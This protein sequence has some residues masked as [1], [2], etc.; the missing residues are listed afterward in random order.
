MDV[1]AIVKNISSLLSCILVMFFSILS[2]L[3]FIINNFGVESLHF[4]VSDRVYYGIL[5]VS[6]ERMTL[7]L[8]Q[9]YESLQIIANS[10]SLCGFFIF[11]IGLISSYLMLGGSKIAKV[12][13]LVVILLSIVSIL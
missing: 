3:Q 6:S 4:N 1:K 10:L 13:G 8:L 5:T 11:G 12:T 9:G 7:G 2:L